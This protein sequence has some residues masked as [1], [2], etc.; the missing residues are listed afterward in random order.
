M[1][2]NNKPFFLTQLV[3]LVLEKHQQSNMFQLFQAIITL[4]S[5]TV[6]NLI[7]AVLYTRCRRN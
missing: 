5:E 4:N 3:L 6:L 7:L 2:Y 1:K